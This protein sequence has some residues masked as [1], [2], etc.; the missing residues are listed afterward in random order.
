[1]EVY[2]D[3]P[4]TVE[5]DNV[6]QVVCVSQHI[7][8][9]AIERF[10]WDPAKLRVIPNSVDVDRFSLPKHDDARRTLAMVGYVPKRKR[11]DRALDIVEALRRQQ[12]RFQLLLVGQPPSKFDWVVREAEEVEYFRRCFARIQ[13]SD[14]LRGGVTFRPFSE[15]LPALFQRVGFV[16]STSESEGHQVALAEGAASGAVPVLIDRPG[17]TDQYPGRWI[18]DTP[19]DAAAAVAALSDADWRSERSLP[20]ITLRPGR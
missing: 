17:A 12:P 13:A 10:G 2:T 3:H 16:L 8:D 18:H 9:E 5:V 14:E 7:A 11:L 1:M 15:D 19:A 4:A 6:D 20:R